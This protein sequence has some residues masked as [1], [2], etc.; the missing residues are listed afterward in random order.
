MRADRLIQVM[1]LLHN[2]GR[3]TSGELA[4]RLEVSERTVHRDMEA[5]SAAGIPVYAE[6]GAGGGWRLAEGYRTTLT[7]LNA[8]EMAALLFE[9]SLRLLADLGKGGAY[10]AAYEKV[11]A[12][13]PERMRREAELV[14]E[15]IHI[16]GAGWHDRDET[17]S[18][19]SDVQEAVWGAR[20]LNIRYERGDGEPVERRI[21]PLGLVAKRTVW[22]VVAEV[23]GEY[24]TYRVSRIGQA[25][26]S[27]ETF[28]RPAAFRL[29]AFWRQ[30]LEQFVQELPVYPARLRLSREGLRRLQAERYARLQDIGQAGEDG[31]SEA[32]VHFHTLESACGL[33]LSLGPELVILEPAELRERLLAQAEAMLRLHRR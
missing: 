24:R 18:C 33:C 7:G 1:L 6:R 8:E 15:R 19:L 30:S 16:D 27:E 28:E 12:A 3:M 10:G 32:T 31:W 20:K 11:W 17:P 2:Y 23:E 13:A 21:H 22:Y 9:G 5:L 4:E 29:D 26:V 25:R 14:R